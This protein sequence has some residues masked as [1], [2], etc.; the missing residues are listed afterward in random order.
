MALRPRTQQVVSIVD[1][2]LNQFNR[3]NSYT[4]PSPV[5]FPS[6][7]PFDAGSAGSSSRTFNKAQGMMNIGA[8]PT[9]LMPQ[10]LRSQREPFRPPVNLGDTSAVAPGVPADVQVGRISARP[11]VAQRQMTP[12]EYAANMPRVPGSDEQMQELG[13]KANQAFLI[14]AKTPELKTDPTFQDR[15]KGFFGD[16]GNML[17]LALAFNSL[18]TT[19]D[20]G[21]TAMLSNELKDLRTENRAVNVAARLRGLGTPE[22]I[23]AAEYIESTGDVK[24]GM[25]MYNKAGSVEQKTGAEL[26]GEAAGY[27]P[28]KIYNVD[29]ITGKVSSIGGGDTTVTVEGAKKD[30]FERYYKYVA[31]NRDAFIEAGKAANTRLGAYG[32][33]NRALDFTATGKEESNRQAIRTMLDG[34]GLSGLIDEKA[35]ANAAAF[36]AAANQLVAEELR[37]NKGPQTDFDAQF[38]QTYIPNLSNPKDANREILKYGQSTAQIQRILGQLANRVDANSETVLQDMAEVNEFALTVPNVVIKADGT[39]MHFYDYYSNNRKADIKDLMQA[40]ILFADRERER[41]LNQ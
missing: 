35:Y 39:V 18:R 6:D 34:L 14:E 2:L 7:R 38:A 21:L 29:K 9:P 40:W 32:R 12:E 27:D 4:A 19:P 1:E 5:P 15:I 22:A 20:Q 30:L 23:R 3:D 16:R 28:K 31:D 26:G 36:N 10:S 11:Q 33:M 37:A 24:G 17:R 8:A 25:N 41:Q 13:R